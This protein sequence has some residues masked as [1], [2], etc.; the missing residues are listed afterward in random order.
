MAKKRA[1]R[2][3]PKDEDRGRDR[4][5]RP[6]GKKT[7]PAPDEKKPARK[8]DPPT[9][10]ELVPMDTSASTL[11]PVNRRD[12]LVAWFELYMA[13]EAG[14]P[15]S[16][17]FKAKKRDLQQFV[18]YFTTAAGT[19]RPD[20]WTRSLT[21][22][23]L[24]YLQN[25]RGLAP[26]SINRTLATLKHASAWIHQQRPFLAGLPCERVQEITIED[27]EWRGLEDLQINRL[28][29]AAEQLIHLNQ[30]ADQNPLRDYATLLILLHTALRVSEL[31]SLDLDQYRG[32]Y[33]ANIKRK[34]KKVT[35]ELLL[36]KPA[37]EALDR[38]L[39]EVRG[40]E[41][42]PLIQS[43]SGWRLAPQNIDDAL[44]KIAAQAN[45]TLPASEQVHLSAHM[46]RHT[47]LRKA[48][49]K[50]DIRY[51]MKLSGHTSSKY[52]WRYTEPSRQEQER[53][54][55]NLF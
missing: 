33:L 47:A 50:E 25:E 49:E 36:A 46:L 52:I 37:R 4:G 12:S 51:A 16:N 28:K 20:F 21:E 44:K 45:A 48:A 5:A 30:R 2:T 14:P 42:G 35:R 11:I 8:K 15:D 31:L 43:Q 54:L 10:R 39:D 24:K 34:G 38:Y 13:I 23:F 1:S 22:G 6:A 18:G 27:P 32:K 40:R 55:E 9:T 53:A 41:P 29:S 26:T 17:T 7:P 19:D 3:P